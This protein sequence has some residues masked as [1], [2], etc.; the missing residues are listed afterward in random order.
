MTDTVTP[1]SVEGRI[2]VEMVIEAEKPEPMSTGQP[3]EPH[4]DGREC[5]VAVVTGK[6]SDAKGVSV[7]DVVFLRSGSCEYAARVGKT[8]IVDGYQVVAKAGKS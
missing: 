4:G 5:D 2:A 7:G 6:S 1:V 3:G 8:F